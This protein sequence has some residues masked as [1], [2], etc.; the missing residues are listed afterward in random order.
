MGEAFP[1][2]RAKI[3]R[4]EE[5]RKV[6]EPEIKAFV[7][8]DPI[9]LRS[10]HNLKR[11]K[12]PIR[13]A[14]FVTK[15]SSAPPCWPLVAGDSI[16]NIRAALDHAVWAIVVEQSG[17]KFAEANSRK[18]YF[19]IT[20][21][22]SRFPHRQL[23][24]LGLTPPVIA[25]IEQAQPYVRQQSAPRDDALWMLR[26]LSNVDKH[27]LLHV[28]TI[29]GEEATVRTTPFLFNGK[30]T[31]VTPGALYEGAEVVRFTAARPTSY[32][33][34]EMELEFRAGICLD[35]TPE[36]RPVAI[37]LGLRTMRDRATEVIDA[38]AVVT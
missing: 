35:A 30:V 36:S 31:F 33:E 22:A 26:A 20:D 18:I 8:S 28:I 6:I 24:Q 2:S 21:K 1:T 38:L 17:A 11:S 9:T 34:V 14:Y 7:E 29:I 23:A 4:A 27:R 19:P 12:E 15:V 16:Q 37:D 10:E 32:P 5:H 25:V 13:I 3:A